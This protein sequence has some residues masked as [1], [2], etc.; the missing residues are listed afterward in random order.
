MKMPTQRRPVVLVIVLLVAL[1]GAVCRESPS[2]PAE[3]NA[4]EGHAGETDPIRLSE[5]AV[6]TGGIAV[7]PAQVR[8]LRRGI[9][10][11]GELGFNRRRLAHLTARAS[12]RIES[13]AAY[14]GERVTEGQTLAE[15]YSQD[16]LALQAEIIQA[17]DRARRL[18]ETPDAGGARAF[19]EAA[20]KKILP[21]GVS[22][23]EID[24]LLSTKS[25]RPLLAVRAPF[26]GRIIE[27]AAVVGDAVEPGTSLFRLADLSTLWASV[28]IYEKD[29]GSVKPGLEVLFGTQSFPGEEFRG[30][31]TVVGAEMDEKTRAVEV[32]AELSNPAERLKPGMYVEAFLSTGEKR[33]A[34]AV[35]ESSLQD[36]ESSSVVFVQTGPGSY[37]LRLV[38]TGERSGGWVEI[39]RGLTEGE[40]VVVAGS[41]LLKSEMLKMRMGD[42]H[43][44]D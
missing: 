42:E 19:L 23:A 34:L 20:R 15:V 44:H 37:V 33:R 2:V 29:L 13:I 39:L 1:A 31:L 14:R 9:K 38:A 40:E 8:E 10:A 28:R 3:E 12:G 24:S 6:R 30:R 43:E 27:Q 25:V 21:L 16:Y 4:R 32:R 26:G 5:E 36:F 41:F 35:P 17:A 7:A 11:S 22:E 18:Q